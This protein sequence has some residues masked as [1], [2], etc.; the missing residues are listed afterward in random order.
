[1]SRAKGQKNT[2]KI[3]RQGICVICNTN[4]QVYKEKGK[5]GKPIF[6][7]TC[8]GCYK[9]PYTRFKKNICEECGF[10]P[11]HRRQ[12]D[13]HHI[14]KDKANNSPD[15]FLTLCANCHRLIHIK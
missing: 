10:I 3:Y 13:L 5:N 14:D 4:L 15:N 11:V 12:L 6:R 2:G 8:Y 1:M 9:K 7:N